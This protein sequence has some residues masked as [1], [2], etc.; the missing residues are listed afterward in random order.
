MLQQVGPLFVLQWAY[1]QSIDMRILSDCNSVFI[2][3]MLTGARVNTR[4]KEVITNTSSFV[5]CKA[6]GASPQSPSPSPE[7]PDGAQSDAESSNGAGSAAAQVQSALCEQQQDGDAAAVSSGT[8]GQAAASHQMVIRPRHD[9][10]VSSHGC[11]LCPANLCKVSQQPFG[12]FRSHVTALRADPLCPAELCRGEPAAV[13]SFPM[14]AV[15]AALHYP[16][17]CAR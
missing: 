4:V 15:R 5:R 7:A 3:H 2:S 9:W 8:G 13:S 17:S 16:T 10:K 11:P 6:P 12:F 1:S 14:T